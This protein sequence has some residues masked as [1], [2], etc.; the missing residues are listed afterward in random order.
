MAGGRGAL[1]GWV[2]FLYYGGIVAL[3]DAANVATTIAAQ[4]ARS[5]LIPIE[6]ASHSIGVRSLTRTPR[7]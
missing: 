7:V 4:A 2:Q 3:A 6:R 1:C 5:A